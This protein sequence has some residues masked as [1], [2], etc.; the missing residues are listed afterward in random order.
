MSVMSYRQ[1]RVL[2]FNENTWKVSD[3]PPKA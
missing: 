1:G 3:Q 2:Y